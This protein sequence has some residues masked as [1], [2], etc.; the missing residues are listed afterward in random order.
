MRKFR[1][2]VAFVW[3]LGSA[4]LFVA[5]LCGAGE[6]DA[7]KKPKEKPFKYDA[8]CA[9]SDLMVDRPYVS[10]YAPIDENTEHV[11]PGTSSLGGFGRRGQWAHV[12]VD[13]KNTT[14]P[15]DKIL[16]E[17]SSTI[18]LNHV[19]PDDT[20]ANT[21][22]TSYR[23]SFQVAPQAEKPYHFSI[24]CPENGWNAVLNVDIATAGGRLYSRDFRLYD[25]DQKGEQLIVVVSDQPGAFKFLGPRMKNRDETDAM[26]D[27]GIK[28]E[29]GRQIASVTPSELPSRWHDLSLA[30]LIIIDGPPVGGLSPSQ[31]DAIKSY[32]QAGGKVLIMAGK[33][34]SRLKG[35]V[36]DLAGI[37]VRGSTELPIL[38]QFE[39]KFPASA[40]EKSTDARVP[41]I[42]VTAAGAGIVRRN[43]ATQIVEYCAKSYGTGM[44]AF[45]PFSLNDRM[46]EG[47]PERFT[48]PVNLI[49][50]EKNLFSV[51]PDESDGTD[52]VQ[53][54]NAQ[55]PY[56]RYNQQRQAKQLGIATLRNVLDTSFTADTP[57]EIQAPRTVLW[58]MIVYLLCAVPLNYVLFFVLRKRE[59]AWLMVPVWAL[60]FTI[61][62]YYIGYSGKTGAVTVNEVS[63]IEAGAGQNT[64]IGRTFMGV[65][66]PRRADYQIEFPPL[67][68][69]KED[70]YDTQ[71]APAPLVNTVTM[72]TRD[73]FDYPQMDIREAGDGMKIES[74]L[75]QNRSTRRFEIQH[76]AWLG[77]GL[78]LKFA[79]TNNERDEHPSIL[80]HNNVTRLAQRVKLIDN[81]NFDKVVFSNAASH[82]ADDAK[83]K[84]KW[85]EEGA[86]I[87]RD[88]DH[89]VVTLER[90]HVDIARSNIASIQTA[91]VG[92]VM[93]NAVF[94][95]NGH[96][97]EFEGEN[98]K[99]DLDPGQTWDS[100]QSNSGWKPVDD[101][102]LERYAVRFR[103]M[104]QDGKHTADRASAVAHYLKDHMKQYVAGVFL[105]WTDGASLPVNIGVTGAQVEEPYL[106]GITLL[107]VP[108][109]ASNRGRVAYKMDEPRAQFATAFSPEVR[110]SGEWKNCAKESIPIKTPLASGRKCVYLRLKFDREYGQYVYKN[111]AAQLTFNIRNKSATN[112]TP[113]NGE[114]NLLV[115]M[116]NAVGPIDRFKLLGTPTAIA[117]LAPG[118]TYQ[119]KTGKIQF[120]SSE[121]FTG[122]SVILKVEPEADQGSVVPDNL[123]IENVQLN[124]VDR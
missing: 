33:D 51:N 3:M 19:K 44:V 69:S 65:Y 27:N 40:S 92:R 22:L 41:I 6:A 61:A 66:A 74:I 43:T 85:I 59:A 94:I 75:I 97:I 96:Y 112:T 53:P 90:G 115:R 101:Q 95:K 28:E 99:R 36:E 110:T 10:P 1:P 16:Y 35:A 124:L 121:L 80:V 39:T 4:L 102:F 46:F 93:R 45:I 2:A 114:V 34:P 42:E 79:N 38:D 81:P 111:K 123:V 67:A 78:D 13:L 5:S 76:R 109:V 47:W 103:E 119:I 108:A 52:D 72:A 18:H 25:L 68:F 88:D 54:N 62:A 30:S 98:S 49:R 8:W 11:R 26:I 107:V 87:Y 83:S 57:V 113:Y 14:D 23:Q 118:S 37:V 12:V 117:G 56:Y 32:T 84:R 58:F 116:D 64:G 71:A 70:V 89:V 120:T 50:A 9:F 29:T 77:G 105:A 24:F 7:D 63:V 91:Q 21:F 122:S 73:Y 15:K 60:T 20:S 100:R 17:G 104:G 31:W 48:I 86:V 106:D 55:Y 82:A